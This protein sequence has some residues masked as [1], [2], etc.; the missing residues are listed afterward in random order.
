MPR[1]YINVDGQGNYTFNAKAS[2]V[3]G[4]AEAVALGNTDW[5]AIN[6]PLTAFNFV[7]E[8][9]LLYFLPLKSIRAFTKENEYEY[10]REGGV[11]DYVHMKRKPISKPFTFQ[12]ERYIGTERFLDPLATGTE[13]IA[14]L[15]LYIYRHKAIGGFND[16]A[17]KNPAR[18]YIFTGCTVMGKEYGELNAEKSGLLTETT[19][20]AYRELIVVPNPT[21]SASELEEWKFKGEN[22][23][24]ATG[25]VKPKYAAYNP[26][27]DIEKS[28][29]YEKKN[30]VISRKEK[31]PGNRPANFWTK[32]N[33]N[34]YKPKYANHDRTQKEYPEDNIYKKEEKNGKTII[35]R[36]DGEA[37]APN[38]LTE[39]NKNNYMPVHVRNS[40]AI[41]NDKTYS[42][43]TDTHGVSTITRTDKFAKEP[44]VLTKDGYEPKYVSN[45][46]AIK[47]DKTYTKDFMQNG[48]PTIIRVDEADNNKA[49]NLLTYDNQ[50]TYQPKWV[51]NSEAI[52][53]DNTYKKITDMHGNPTVFRAD[54]GDAKNTLNKP[55]YEMSVDKGNTKYAKKPEN[56]SAKPKQVGP[57]SYKKDGTKNVAAK[58]SPKDSDRAKQVGPYKYSDGTN[59]VAARKSPKDS[60][61]PKQ[62]GP[63]KYGDGT[64]NVAAKPSPKDSEKPKQVGPYSVG[65]DGTSNVAAKTSPRDKEKPVA[66]VFPPSRR[67]LMADALKK[68]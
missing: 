25:N 39:D 42:K 11:N 45:A 59:N 61:K 22:D 68:T 10:I 3:Y 14:P 26:N 1:T 15:F 49:P 35:T 50:T 32:E 2:D 53:N 51:R 57:Y 60:E 4:K 52:Q 37:K 64:R 19:T 56:D 36:N 18:V 40:E 58:K 66:S 8:V 27:D 9:E 7:L 65:K 34:N 41:K 47:N 55:Q 30:G 62:V 13:L 29:Y 24:A 23:A 31:S 38:L 20:I 44:N 5:D 46:E 48:N 21:Q 43:S 17:P 6:N 63:Y 54:A 28:L 12:V 16:S 33:K 67:A